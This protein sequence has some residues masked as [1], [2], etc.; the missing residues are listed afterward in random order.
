MVIILQMVIVFIYSQYV[1]CALYKNTQ[2][3]T[4]TKLVQVGMVR[5]LL[6]QYYM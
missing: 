6:L 5:R 3:R 1:F 2:R 4:P